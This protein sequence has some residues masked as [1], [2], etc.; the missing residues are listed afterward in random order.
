MNFGLYLSNGMKLFMHNVNARSRN[1][2]QMKCS[3]LHS[4]AYRDALM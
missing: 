1:H 4:K 3:L 2:G